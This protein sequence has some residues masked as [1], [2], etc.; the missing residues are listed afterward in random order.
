MDT[1]PNVNQ[2][3]NWSSQHIAP[4]AKQEMEYT[5]QLTASLTKLTDSAIGEVLLLTL[6]APSNFDLP[7][8]R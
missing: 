2:T 6:T 5:S 4:P 7:F 3:L 1:S 8:G